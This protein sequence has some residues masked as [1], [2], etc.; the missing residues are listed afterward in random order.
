MN[1]LVTF[2]PLYIC[3][4]ILSFSLL[5][6]TPLFAAQYEDEISTDEYLFVRGMVHSVSLADQSITIQQKKG[7]RITILVNSETVLKGFAQLGELPI[8]H[9]V[10]IWYHPAKKGNIGLK[11]LKLPGLGC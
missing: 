6:S 2:K 3:L 1:P 9:E 5:L 10:K 4:A 7:P 11:I 8:G